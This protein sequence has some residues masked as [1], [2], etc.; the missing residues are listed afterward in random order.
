MFY[1]LSWYNLWRTW[2]QLEWKFI[3]TSVCC[4]AV[5]NHLLW[6][7]PGFP[8][9]ELKLESCLLTFH[10]ISPVSSTPG[11]PSQQISIYRIQPNTGTFSQF[12]IWWN[13][14]GWYLKKMK[15]IQEYISCSAKDRIT[16][17]GIWNPELVFI[18]HEIH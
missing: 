4:D 9:S 16:I 13:H 7:I 2:V 6:L 10:C 18:K 14:H 12:Y 8:E 17:E 1:F 5:F 3:C 11:K 15:D